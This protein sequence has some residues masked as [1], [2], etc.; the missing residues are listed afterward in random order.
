MPRVNE[1]LRSRG[2]SEEVEL[3][4]PNSTGCLNV[5]PA[6]P[7]AGTCSTA[8]AGRM[9]LHTCFLYNPEDSCIPIVGSHFELHSH[10]RSALRN[11]KVMRL[12]DKSLSQELMARRFQGPTG[13]KD[14]GHAWTIS[15][16]SSAIWTDATLSP[17]HR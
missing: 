3:Q 16:K 17:S 6:D 1:H 5:V 13:H 9:S 4:P 8:G 15:S 14:R 7:L 10:K 11:C 12:L 2:S